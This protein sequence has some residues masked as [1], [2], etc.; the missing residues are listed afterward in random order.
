MGW[1]AP[2]ENLTLSNPLWNLALDLW[3]RPSFADACLEAQSGGIVVTHVLVALQSAQTGF[4][5]SGREPDELREWRHVMTERLRN[6][7]R[8][9]DRDNPALAPLRRQ[10]ADS[11]LASEQVELAWW[12]YFL[13]TMPHWSERS[14]LDPGER[15]RHNLVSIGL[16]ESLAPLRVRI[17]DAW[18]Q[19]SEQDQ[20]TWNQE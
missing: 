14:D 9:L 5:W 19:T 10:V 15:A 3:D 13:G 2:P 11:E 4:I 12:W 18:Q 6:L 7:R 16:E 20:P 17:I 1:H 8:S